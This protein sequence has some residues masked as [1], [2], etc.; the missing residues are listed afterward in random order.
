MDIIEYLENV[1]NAQKKANSILYLGYVSVLLALN[2]VKSLTHVSEREIVIATKYIQL[3]SAYVNQVI[4]EFM[5]NAQLAQIIVNLIN[6]PDFVH[7]ELDI[8]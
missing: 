2:I 5:A 1:L 7:V 6:Q 8:H 4:R 3:A